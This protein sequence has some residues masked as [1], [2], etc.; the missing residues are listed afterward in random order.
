M[1]SLRLK[2][3]TVCFV[4]SLLPLQLMQQ[5]AMKHGTTSPGTLIALFMKHLVEER[6]EVVVWYEQEEKTPK[7]LTVFQLL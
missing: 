1:S 7:S 5:H 6:E 2:K 3:L 4:E